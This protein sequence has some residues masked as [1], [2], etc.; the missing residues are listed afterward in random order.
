MR[1]LIQATHYVW[2]C[3]TE[4]ATILYDPFCLAYTFAH[5]NTATHSLASTP[6]TQTHNRGK[7]SLIPDTSPCCWSD[8]VCVCVRAR[9]PVTKTGLVRF[10]SKTAV[11]HLVWHRR[12]W[13]LRKLYG[14]SDCLH[15]FLSK[16]HG[17]PENMMTSLLVH[18]AKEA[19]FTASK[20]PTLSSCQGI[21]ATL[22]THPEDF[23]R[24]WRWDLLHYQN[25]L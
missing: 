24:N 12:L 1:F 19:S 21:S 25:K 16:C 14:K 17:I 4:I 22:A 3:D 10:I 13:Y 7:E 11:S 15:R 2:L 23:F 18:T 6:L 20:S 8:G 5:I 9:V